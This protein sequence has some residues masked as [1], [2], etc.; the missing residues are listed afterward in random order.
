[1][2][3]TETNGWGRL[4]FRTILKYIAI[5]IVMFFS[6]IFGIEFIKQGYR[7]LGIGLMIMAGV[8]WC[9]II[10]GYFIDFNRNINSGK[11]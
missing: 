6:A 3:C 4:T 8:A 2:V 10:V 5:P 1:M 11:Q 9:A 7:N